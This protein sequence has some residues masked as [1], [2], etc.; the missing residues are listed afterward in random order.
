M[1]KKTA[2]ILSAL[3]S[4]VALFP[5]I[6]HA[7]F[8]CYESSLFF[9]QSPYGTVVSITLPF[10][11]LLLL[12][13]LTYRMKN[14]VFLAWWRFAWWW[15]LIIAGVTLFLNTAGGGGGIGIEGAISTG[16]DIFV[17]SILYAVLIIVSVVKIVRAY[18]R[19]R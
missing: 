14:E 4:L 3:G 9:C 18:L 1:T 10:F 2:L 17:L 7:L 13:L 8:S 5:A 11:P 15:A 19:T 16:F 6:W 12:T